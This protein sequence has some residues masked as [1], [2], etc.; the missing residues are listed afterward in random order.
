MNQ[1]KIEAWKREF[2][3]DQLCIRFGMLVNIPP[4]ACYD[5]FKVQE[6]AEQCLDNETIIVDTKRRKIITY[7]HGSKK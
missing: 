2:L 5:N 1:A 3:R 4:P 6:L 7:R